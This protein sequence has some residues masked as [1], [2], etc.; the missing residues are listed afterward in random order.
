[1]E[2]VPS[3]HADVVIQSHIIRDGNE[4]QALRNARVVAT[5]DATSLI[6]RKRVLHLHTWRRT[7]SNGVL[8]RAFISAA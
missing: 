2:S 6:C 5:S 1:L 3:A 4:E 8:T 7:S